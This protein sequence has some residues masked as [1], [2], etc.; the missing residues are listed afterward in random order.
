LVDDLAAVIRAASPSGAPAVVVGE[1][2]GGTVAMSLALSRPDLVAGLVVLNSF[3]YFVPRERLR[4][5]IFALRALPFP[6]QV[7][8][9]V[10]RLTAFRLHSRHTH[11]AEIKRFLELTA[12]T[13]RPA[14]L[15]RLRILLAYDVRDRLAEIRAPT[16]FLAAEHDHLVPSVEQAR[17]M[18]AL[19]PG[20][21]FRVLAGHGHICLIAPDIDLETILARWGPPAGNQGESMNQR[22]HNLLTDLHGELLAARDVSPKDRDLLQHL[23]EDIR[24]IVEAEPASHAPATYHPLRQRLAEGVKAFEASHPQ[25][26]KTLANA[27]DTLALYNL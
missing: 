17:D 10:R 9:L 26:S 12:A 14:Y 15:A 3:P 20:A 22:L 18:A 4:L 1:S 19:V 7:M 13:T 23:A 8:G 21:T 5:A 25:L 6:W 24:T 16:L 27:I 11:R 2:F